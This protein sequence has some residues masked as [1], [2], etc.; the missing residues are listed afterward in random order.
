MS[1]AR[2]PLT[3]VGGS[4]AALVAA[5]AAARDGRAVDLLLPR[6]G[7]GGGFSPLVLDGRRLER[8]VRLIEVHWEGVGD[9][10]PLADYR[11]EVD[12]HR[13]YARLLREW[14]EELAGDDLVEVSRPQMFFEGRTERELYWATDLSRLRA[15]LGP[16][17]ADAVAAEA[18]ISAQRG[19]A[20]GVL[21][22]ERSDESWER[23]L[24]EGSVANHGETFHRLLIDPVCRKI[25]P[26]GGDDVPLRLRRKLWM[27]VYWPKTVWEAASGRELSFKPE[28]PFHSIRPGG[29]SELVDRLLARLE[30]SP[31]A[32][33]VRTGRVERIAA[34]DRGAVRI[35]FEGGEQHTA[36]RPVLG[37]APGE[38]FAAAG[39]EYAPERVHSV[40]C[41]VEL[42][43]HDLLEL[44]SMLHAVDADVPVFRVTAGERDAG[45]GRRTLTVELS[46]DVA[47]EEI[48]AATRAGLE[49]IGIVREGAPLA[50]IAAFAGRTFTAPTRDSHARFEQARAAFGALGLDAEI[51]GG[52]ESFG[53]DTLN[54]QLVQGLRAAAVAA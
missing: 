26:Q 46:H 9:P 51:V 22:A 28:R 16:A 1:A 35:G 13:P 49:R 6:K 30:R 4:V 23:Y 7:V 36:R 11:P 42:S 37:L 54:D 34:G 33:I 52:A 21:A 15:L 24:T 43:E 38:L 53:A 19:G 18:A 39:V 47:E 14:V 40:L 27:P 8:G 31:A 48:P 10:P 45:R 2:A 32:R 29:A 41:W 50:T 25:R 44:P 12:A 3:V 17:H 5:D 20:A